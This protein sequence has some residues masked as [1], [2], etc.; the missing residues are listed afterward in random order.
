MGEYSPSHEEAIRLIEKE[1]RTKKQR[2]ERIAEELFQK[3]LNG[4]SLS[5]FARWRGRRAVGEAA[6][7]SA[8]ISNI[9]AYRNGQDLRD[10]P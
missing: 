9:E 3:E 5:A 6:Y 4:I 7:Y 1:A 10:L 8:V 2:Y